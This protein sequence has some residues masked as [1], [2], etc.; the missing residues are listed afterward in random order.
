MRW[1]FLVAMLVCLMGCNKQSAPEKVPTCAELTTKIS[2]LT[3]IAY[4]GHGEMEMGNSKRDIAICEEKNPS[5][6]ERKCIMAAKDVP[7]IAACRKD[8]VKQ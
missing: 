5:P 8:S 7:G 1:I 2:E 3:K 4:P 6:K